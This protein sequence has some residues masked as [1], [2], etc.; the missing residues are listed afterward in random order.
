MADRHV[1]LDGR[2]FILKHDQGGCLRAIHERKLHMPGTPMEC[3][4]DPVIWHRN[5]NRSKGP[6]TLIS[7]IIAK[8]TEELK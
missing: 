4:Y 2:R 5:R 8:A 1:R 7:R 6:K 3:F